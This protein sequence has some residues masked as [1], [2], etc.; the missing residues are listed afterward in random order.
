MSDPKALRAFGHPL[1]QRILLELA[2]RDHARAADLAQAL[3]E[4]A[5]SISFH[6]RTLAAAGLVAE[7]PEHARDRRDRVWRRVADRFEVD[8]SAPGYEAFT[9]PLLRW[10][11]E[12]LADTKNPRRR[13][14]VTQIPLTQDE[15]A[16]LAA[17]VDAVVAR[18]S[19][20]GR[21]AAEEHPDDGSRILYQAVFLA[22]PP[23]AA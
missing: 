15:L 20:H 17:E 4:P 10:T 3:G 12:T 7:A 16:Q 1:R 13:A 6:L 18:W 2:W 11:R 5:N 23:D 21:R 14:S 8:S 19:T 22:G 9:A